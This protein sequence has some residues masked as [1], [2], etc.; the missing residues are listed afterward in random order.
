MSETKIK[1]SLFLEQPVVPVNNDEDMVSEVHKTGSVLDGESV[2]VSR[3]S[4]NEAPSDVLEN[5]AAFKSKSQ[6]KEIVPKRR[7]GRSRK[8]L[9]EPGNILDSQAY[10]C[11]HCD[12]VFNKRGI[13]TGHITITHPD[14][15]LKC[16]NCEATFS[17]EDDLAKHVRFKHK[18][19]Q[20][21][22]CPK[23]FNTMNI[24]KTHKL[25][26]HK[27]AFPI[28]KDGSLQSCVCKICNKTFRSKHDQLEHSKEIHG[29]QLFDIEHACLV[30]G[31]I[32][33]TE[34]ALM[35]HSITH[36]SVRRFLCT[37]CG[38]G[39]KRVGHLHDHMDLHSPEPKYQC[40][41]CGKKIAT[42]SILSSHMNVHKKVRNHT[43]EICGKAFKT[44]CK[45]KDHVDI[46]LNERRHKCEF[47]GK[48]FNNNGTLWLHRKN[49][50][51]ASKA[52]VKVGSVA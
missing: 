29:V 48:G 26:R 19:I 21:S 14:K 4:Q 51:N 52:K 42:K 27:D 16:D 44:D 1:T 30:C 35:S 50:H 7:R 32:F 38:K 9:G 20:C 43:C 3:V 11:K 31:K 40:N 17:T 8:K 23:P 49:V 5:K 24:F 39:F 2:D 47:C 46:H 37:I 6:V 13:L 41:V 33:G 25:T 28:T 18:A 36:S 34:H 12:K 10:E 45:L 15:M 22:E